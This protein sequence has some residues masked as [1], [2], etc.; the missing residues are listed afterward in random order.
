M[1][2]MKRNFGLI[3][4]F[5]G[6]LAPNAAVAA[7]NSMAI[8]QE[9]DAQYTYVGGSAT[10]GAGPHVGSVSEH[11][12]DVKYVFSPQITK[13]LLL[14]FGV[15]WQRFSFDVPDHARVPDLLQQAS[16]VIGLDYQLGDQ[17]LVRAELEPGMYSDFEDSDFRDF[18]APLVLGAAYLA[19]ADLQWFFGLRV[20]LRSNYPVLPAPGVRWKFADEWT[21]NLAFPNPRLEYDVNDRFQVYLGANV[22]SGTFVVGDHFGSDR[23]MPKLNHATL[24]YYAIRVGPGCS[25]KVSPCLTLEA[26]GGLMLQ[27]RFDFFDQDTT[28]RNHEAPYLQIACHARF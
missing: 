10:R 14:R 11:C 6:L 20:D 23:G 18:N 16:V 13:D 12:A 28:I 19:D 1:F 15:E 27:R 3:L 9:L 5:A 26:S 17:W 21:L 22:E 2:W 8:S 7:D 4:A 24:D 25:W